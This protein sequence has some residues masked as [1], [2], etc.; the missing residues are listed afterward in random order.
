MR[1]QN[2]V[3]TTNVAGIKAVAYKT[4][5]YTATSADNVI[6]CDSAGS[7]TITLPNAVGKGKEFSVKSIGLGTTWIDGSGAESIDGA[8]SVPVY[9]YDSITVVD[10][11]VGSW[12][13]I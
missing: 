4:T 6:I 2:L 11:T 8:A 5:D 3:L 12:V 13:V 7:V 9:Q 10:Y 1:L